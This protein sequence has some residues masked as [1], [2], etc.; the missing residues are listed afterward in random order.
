MLQMA[1][2]ESFIAIVAA[3]ALAVLNYIFISQRESEFGLL[4]ALG[5]G[6]LQLVWR[7]MR[8]TFF[9]TGIAWA[10]SA[11]LCFLGLLSLQFVVFAPL[12]LRLNFINL[13]PWFFT[14][15]I[16]VLVIA[17]TTSTIARTLSRL[18]PVSIIERR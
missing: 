18:D 6:R 17:V 16:P 15:P 7:T 10:F 9:T 5:Y 8:E 1:L 13:T 3:I 11:F 2:L 14:L 12:G 4:N